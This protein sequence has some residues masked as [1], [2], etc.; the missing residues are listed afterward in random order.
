ML[1]FY[2]PFY[3]LICYL[4]ILLYLYLGNYTRRKTDYFIDVVGRSQ[5]RS[6]LSLHTRFAV[7]VML[8]KYFNWDLYFLLL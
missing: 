4:F 8:R 5:F 2:I 3:I 7:A 6:N 1:I